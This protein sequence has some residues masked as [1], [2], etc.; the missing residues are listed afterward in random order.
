MLRCS[1][2]SAA[3]PAAAWSPPW[4]NCS[5][6]RE[7][8]C[9]SAARLWPYWL[10]LALLLNFVEVAMRKGHFRRLGAWL[11]RRLDMRRKP[12]P[13]LTGVAGGASEAF[14]PVRA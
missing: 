1:P 2:K 9:A 3:S 6:T 7:A 10:V 12:E 4:R 11:Q 8:T 5:M 14:K 13:G